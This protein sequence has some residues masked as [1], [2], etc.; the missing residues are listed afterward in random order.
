MKVEPLDVVSLTLPKDAIERRGEITFFAVH[1]MPR[2]GG[3]PWVVMR[4]YNDFFALQRQL[5]A[6]A[7]AFSDA[8][9][10]KKKPFGCTGQKLEDRRCGLEAW[11][12]RSVEFAENREAWWSPLHEFLEDQRCTPVMSV[13]KHNANPVAQVP[14][15]PPPTETEHVVPSAMQAFQN[16]P[17]DGCI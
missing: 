8:P 6:H 15:A 5:G 17:K 11:L 10:P 14:S 3:E 13:Q 7:Q 1:V 4:R 9:F 12:R 2:T 16:S